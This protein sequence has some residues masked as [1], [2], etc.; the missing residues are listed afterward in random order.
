MPVQVSGNELQTSPTEDDC[1]PVSSLSDD[2]TDRLCVSFGQDL[3]SKR[4][5]NLVI[6]P[7]PYNSSLFENHVNDSPHVRKE[8]HASWF[9]ASMARVEDGHPSPS[10]S[11][12]P[13]SD[14]DG[15]DSASSASTV[16]PLNK[17]S[18][19]ASA[20][21]PTYVD[22]PSRA[23]PTTM[24]RHISHT[25]AIWESAPPT[26]DE[27]MSSPMISSLVQATHSLELIVAHFTNNKDKVQEIGMHSREEEDVNTAANFGRMERLLREK[28]HLQLKPDDDCGGRNFMGDA[29]RKKAKVHFDIPF[30]AVAKK[31]KHLG[32]RRMPEAKS[33]LGGR[34]LSS[35]KIEG[36]AA[37]YSLDL[38]CG[39]ANGDVPP[40]HGP[41]RNAPHE[42]TDTD[43]SQLERIPTTSRQHPFMP[44]ECDSRID[45]PGAA[46]FSTLSHAHSLSDLFS[47]AVVSKS[48][49]RTFKQNEL[50]LMKEALFK[51][52]PPA[53]E[54]REMNPPW[55]S[56]WQVLLDPDSTVPEYTAESYLLHYAQDIYTLVQLKSLI[57]AHCGSFLRRDTILGLAG[58][59]SFHAQEID[60]AFWRVWTFCRLFGC[61]KNREND[62]DGQI[63]WLSGGPVA[64][65]RQKEAF[66]FSA[67]SDT[68]S[69]GINT[70]L[71][72]PP[73]GF[74]GGNGNGLS[75]KQLYDVTEIWTCVCVLL[76]QLHGECAVARQVGIYEHHHVPVG[77]T[78]KE[79]SML[80]ANEPF[81]SFF[82][83]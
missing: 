29:K 27:P 52:S 13:I 55:N 41:A 16:L 17:L 65:I 44:L 18:S 66:D 53:W 31:S 25:A 63:D 48:F 36:T 43:P 75:P 38:P 57:L 11:V 1:S 24:H 14:G 56:E 51:M 74:G 71:L 3:A 8:V 62:L 30:A 5:T 59:D 10:F 19:L 42:Y 47:M 46:I 2:D 60:D 78:V 21:S 67:S 40:Q 61:G 76:Q 58:I 12:S 79:E 35:I 26:I 22:T 33:R 54:F 50:S 64:Q 39:S 69:Y 7:R 72:E 81:P 37:E 68:C 23:N 34:D 15:F 49:Y 82:F 77:D 45:L 83:F 6:S 9:R 20:S 4:P 70:V 73:A 28:P 80:G 32:M